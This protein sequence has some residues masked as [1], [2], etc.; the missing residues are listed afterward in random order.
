MATSTAS[1]LMTTSS[2]TF[3]MPPTSDS[4]TGSPD[5]NPN[6]D[7]GT[8]NYYFVFLAFI[9][10][11]AAV[12]GWLLYRRRRRA[13]MA[14]HMS[15]D[16][17]QSR[18]FT[19]WHGHGG[20]AQ[21]ERLRAHWHGQRFRSQEDMGREEGLNELG[22]APPAYAPPPRK[23]RDGQGQVDGAGDGPAVPMQ[24]LSRENAGLKPP[25]YVETDV[26]PEA[27]VRRETDNS[28]ASARRAERRLVV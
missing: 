25:D 17:A 26:R 3:S 14:A 18:D 9:I 13:M 28:G 1:T 21:A 24:T 2:P 20:N 11:V 5:S 23:S 12:T 22:E 27:P 6:P 8:V 7:G 16:H 4:A 19:T 15:R 10:C